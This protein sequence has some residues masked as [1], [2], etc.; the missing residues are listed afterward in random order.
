MESYKQ[1]F[2]YIGVFT[3]VVLFATVDATYSSK[4]SKTCFDGARNV[5][6][7]CVNGHCDPL[8]AFSRCECDPGYYGKSCDKHDKSFLRESIIGLIILIPVLIWIILRVYNRKHRISRNSLIRKR[9]RPRSTRRSVE[10]GH[11]R[12]NDDGNSQPVDGGDNPPNYTEAVNSPDGTL[13]QHP[14]PLFM[15]SS[16]T[17]TDTFILPSYDDVLKEKEQHEGGGGGETTK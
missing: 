2:L 4:K 11:R 16:T 8:A 5:T 15:M 7:R 10:D 6:Y 1:L 9:Q 3:A 17:Q 13:S 14:Y 12:D